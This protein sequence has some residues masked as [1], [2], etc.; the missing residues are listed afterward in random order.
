MAKKIQGSQKI[1]GGQ[2]RQ[3]TKGLVYPS[4][5]LRTMRLL[6]ELLKTSVENLAGEATKTTMSMQ[7]HMTLLDALI[8]SY[9]EDTPLLD[10][11]GQ[12]LAD[13][14]EHAYGT[15]EFAK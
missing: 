15:R 10:V 4:M 8:E 14:E 13:A 12:I 7:D 3:V 11:V 6:H 5:T 9:G 2:N 1:S